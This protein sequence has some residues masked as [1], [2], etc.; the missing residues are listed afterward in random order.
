MKTRKTPNLADR[1][2]AFRRKEEK[3]RE[4]I[5]KILAKREAKKAIGLIHEDS[6]E[7]NYVKIF[8]CSFEFSLIKGPKLIQ[9]LNN[10][11]LML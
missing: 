6:N 8:L 3:K 7:V 1:I 10:I 2:A 4:K 5:N 9:T 11:L